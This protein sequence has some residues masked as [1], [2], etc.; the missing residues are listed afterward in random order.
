[1]INPAS[2]AEEAKV[3]GIGGPIGGAPVGCEVQPGQRALWLDGGSA[4][5]WYSDEPTAK[6]IEMVYERGTINNIWAVFVHVSL[7]ELHPI[8]ASLRMKGGE[9]FWSCLN[10]TDMP[11]VKFS[12]DKKSD[13]RN[14]S[15]GR[16]GP[17]NQSRSISKED[18]VPITYEKTPQG[19]F[20]RPSQR[21]IP[22]EYGFVPQ[23]QGVFGLGERVYTFG[24]D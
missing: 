1:M 4:A 19:Y 2:K 15:L 21:L 16:G 10:P 17:Y 3:V 9:V 23:G 11:L 14:T 24:I 6:R 7:L 22:A 5:M 18:L 20:I 12:L 13:E 8:K